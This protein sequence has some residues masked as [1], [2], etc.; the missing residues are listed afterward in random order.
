MKTNAMDVVSIG[1][2]SPYLRDV[3]ALCTNDVQRLL[4]ASPAR[5]AATFSVMDAGGRGAFS[6]TPGK[7]TLL[8]YSPEEL[9]NQAGERQG[10]AL[11]SVVLYRGRDGQHVYLD[12]ASHAGTRVPLDVRRAVVQAGGSVLHRAAIVLQGSGIGSCL[13]FSISFMDF[14]INNSHVPSE[15]LLPLYV[16]SAEPE[17]NVYAVTSAVRVFREA[18]LQDTFTGPPHILALKANNYPRLDG[19][20]R[21]NE[22]SRQ[23]Q[24]D[25]PFAML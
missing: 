14:A 10:E 15:S 22:A 1:H 4:A 18:G 3:R 7:G 19:H 20:R 2:F 24:E 13:Y 17:R 23:V 9:H 11:H 8:Y 6:L 16:Q 5:L 21:N 12:S 25:G